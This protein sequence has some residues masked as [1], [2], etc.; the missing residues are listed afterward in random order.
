MEQFGETEKVPLIQLTSI[1]MGQSPSS[2]SY[3]TVGEGVP[4][5]QGSGEFTDKYVGDGMFCT[6]PTR[7]A[8]A[9]DV[10]MSVRA[11]VGTVNVTT[12]DC[13]IGRGLAAIRSK[14][15]ADYNEYF[16]YAFR[17]MADQLGAMGHGSTILAINKNELHNLMM[18]NAT[19]PEQMK[20]VRFA[21]QSDKS[22]S[23]LLKARSELYECEKPIS[24]T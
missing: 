11:P 12:K 1:V 24:N 9:G 15:S 17:A 6:E 7:M 21:R 5:Y 14:V 16:L 20:F 13:C 3:N 22:K 10:L 19:L 18:P 4:F 8:R 23:N 2:D